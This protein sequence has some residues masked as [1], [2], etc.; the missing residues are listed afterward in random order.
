MGHGWV[1][2]FEE[3]VQVSNAKVE[4]KR[5]P[6]VQV[7]GDSK[8]FNVAV[9]DKANRDVICLEMHQNAQ[10]QDSSR[11]CRYVYPAMYGIR[12]CVG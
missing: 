6:I 8:L 11:Q 2:C 7:A 9:I 5:V 1:Q 3:A 12:I 10:F 4:I